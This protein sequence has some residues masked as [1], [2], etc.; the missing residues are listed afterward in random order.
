MKRLRCR[1][2]ALPGLVLLV[3]LVVAALSRHLEQ[4]PVYRVDAVVSLL[5]RNP[6][7][8]VGKTVWVR[9][10]ALACL[11]SGGPARVLHCQGRPQE[12]RDPGPGASDSLPLAWGTQPPW[13]AFLR[14]V[15]VLGTLLPAA[16]A[17]HWGAD[18]TYHVQFRTVPADSCTALP[19]FQA[20]LLD[21]AP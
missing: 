14:G 2:V 16:Q 9:G 4:A 5:A 13:L 20:Q 18:A 12:I 11:P 21:A 7:A 10:V 3:G 8:W 15:P 6:G 17:P 19:C 1:L